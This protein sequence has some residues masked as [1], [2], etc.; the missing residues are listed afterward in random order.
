M[1]GG[2]ELR[3]TPIEKATLGN[4]D[5]QNPPNPPAPSLAGGPEYATSTVSGSPVSAAEARST[6]RT[7]AAW[8]KPVDPLGV[9]VTED[10]VICDV[11]FRS[12]DVSPSTVDSRSI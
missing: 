9:T 10:T 12:I 1:D 7:S 3:P 5:H 2:V 4:A 11:R 8:L 6:L